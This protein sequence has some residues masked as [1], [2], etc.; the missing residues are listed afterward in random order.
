MKRLKTS[1]VIIC[2]GSTVEFWWQIYHKNWFSDWALICYHY[3]R[4]H[5]KY[6]N[7]KEGEWKVRAEGGCKIASSSGISKSFLF[8]NVQF[9]LFLDVLSIFISIYLCN[10]NSST[11]R[12]SDVSGKKNKSLYVTMSICRQIVF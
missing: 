9:I 10:S 3:W 11:N 8:S 12:H 6:K 7:V 4:W 1:S 5:W 2:N